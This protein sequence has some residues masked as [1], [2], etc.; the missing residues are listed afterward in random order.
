MFAQMAEQ[1]LLAKIINGLVF[2]HTRPFRENKNAGTVFMQSGYPKIN[3][4][5][6]TALP[7]AHNHAV[8]AH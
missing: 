3:C 8:F 6:Q 4:R 1:S 5:Q 2:I 7:I